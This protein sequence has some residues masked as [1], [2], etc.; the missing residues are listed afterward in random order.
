MHALVRFANIAAGQG[1]HSVDIHPAA[2]E[3]LG[4]KES[5]YTLSCFRYDLSKLRAKG[6]GR[7]DPS[8]PPVPPGCHG[9]SVCLIFLKLFERIYAPLAAGLLKPFFPA[10]QTRRREVLHAGPPISADR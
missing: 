2:L 4:A 8:F 5:E 3:S 9:Y 6:S 1:F 7:K 10:P